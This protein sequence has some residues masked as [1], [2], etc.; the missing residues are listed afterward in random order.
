MMTKQQL[1]ELK[2]N[3]NRIITQLVKCDQIYLMDKQ[4]YSDKRIVLFLE[5]LIGVKIKTC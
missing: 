3:E 4:E 5:C 2:S 1:N